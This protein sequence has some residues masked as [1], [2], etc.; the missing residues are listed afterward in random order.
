MADVCLWVR[1]VPACTNF[2]LLEDVIILPAIRILHSWGSHI[3]FV[4]YNVRNSSIVY[5]A[6]SFQK[7]VAGI[8][9]KTV[10]FGVTFLAER[11]LGLAKLWLCFVVKW[12]VAHQA[13][14]VVRTD[15]LWEGVSWIDLKA[16]WVF[17]IVGIGV[18]HLHYWFCYDNCSGNRC[19]SWLWLGLWLCLGWWCWKGDLSGFGGWSWK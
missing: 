6:V 8:A 10:V 19:F 9:G 12:M 1:I 7:D 4:S 3:V 2:A 18:F 5:L 16:V 15:G 11:I 13:S 17:L 14:F